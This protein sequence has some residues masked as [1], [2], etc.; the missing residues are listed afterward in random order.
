[1]A[2]DPYDLVKHDG[3]TVDRITHEALKEAERRLG[4]ELT[5]T[6][7]SY[8]GGSGDPDSA[9]THDG[10]GVVDLTAFEALR[11]VKVLRE[12]GFF[13]YRRL[14]SEGDWP[15]HVH[16]GLIGNKK[17]S[18]SAKRQET[19][20]FNG[21]NGMANNG[22]DPHPRPNPIPT[23]RWPPVKPQPPSAPYVK[24]LRSHI[25]AARAVGWKAVTNS[26]GARRV[27]LNAGQ[28]LLASALAVI[29]KK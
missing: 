22:R 28:R 4:Y 7:G 23:F 20:Y 8:R 25:N 24:E 21:R 29:P 19:A 3:K 13:A 15:E 27:A 10:G 5:I 14:P 11:K 16:A 2:N 1:M 12:V 18:P 9:G 26:T 17:L 6:Q